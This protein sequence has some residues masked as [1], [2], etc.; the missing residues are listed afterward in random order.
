MAVAISDEHCVLP[1]SPE[2]SV[3]TGT[4]SN[5][6]SLRLFKSIFDL[7]KH[8]S[9]ALYLASYVLLL[10]DITVR[11]VALNTEVSGHVQDL[12]TQTL[13]PSLIIVMV[14][15]LAGI[16]CL[17]VVIGCYAGRKPVLKT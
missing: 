2:R 16:K 8:P 10:P 9:R 6:F 14:M 1:C 17:K 7:T 11:C 15:F 12:P 13:I 4:S 5:L 3:E